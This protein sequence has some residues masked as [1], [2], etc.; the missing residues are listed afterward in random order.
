MSPGLPEW[1]WASTST[2]GSGPSAR[3]ITDFEGW[4]NASSGEIWPLRSSSAT[5]EWSW[6]SCSSS[7]S[8]IR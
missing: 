1:V 8:R 4:S 5:R 7:P 6:V 3:V 2:S